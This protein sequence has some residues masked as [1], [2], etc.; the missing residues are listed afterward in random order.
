MA[1]PPCQRVRKRCDCGE[2]SRGWKRLKEVG[3]QEMGR[4]GGRMQMKSSGH[5][6]EGYAT[7]V[8]VLGLRIGWPILHECLAEEAI[9]QSV[10]MGIALKAMPRSFDFVEFATYASLS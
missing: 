3:K 6:L 4:R 1:K 5:G 8:A 10:H 9:D 7:G 2:G